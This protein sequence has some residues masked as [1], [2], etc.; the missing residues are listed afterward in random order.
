[1]RFCFT[2]TLLLA[3]NFCLAQVGA[4]KGYVV[5][6][7]DSTYVSGISVALLDSS[8]TAASTYTD[9][10]GYFEIFGIKFG[11]YDLKLA[12]VA[13]PVKLVKRIEIAPNVVSERRIN[14]PDP[15][16]PAKDKIC[17][18][19]HSNMIIPIIYGM[20]D[21][22]L[23]RRAKN[24]KVFLGGCLVSYCDPK[25]HCKLHKIVF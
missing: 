14:F 18:R 25:W 1:M 16:S 15:C 8:G 9:E 6:I 10:K 3:S 20:P 21:N 5:N 7:D 11:F 24:G 23:I 4:L 19:G 17:P 2:I 22:T 12:V 13:Y